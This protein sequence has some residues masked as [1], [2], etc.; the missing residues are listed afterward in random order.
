MVIVPLKLLQSIF[1]DALVHS[2]TKIPELGAVSVQ[3]AS[4]GSP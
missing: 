1:T 3:N 4:V 2:R